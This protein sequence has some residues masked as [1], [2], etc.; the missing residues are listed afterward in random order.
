MRGSAVFGLMLLCSSVYAQAPAAKPA[1]YTNPK[2]AIEDRVADLLGRMT[3]PEKLSILALEAPDSQRLNTPAIP[4]L[5]VPSLRTADAPQG[6]HDGQVTVFPTG[7]TMASTF[8]PALIMKVGETIGQEAR[9]RDRQV[10]YG[11]DLNMHRTPQG[12]RGFE[13]F[14][15]DPFLTATM[16]V[17]YVK[18][19]QSQGVAACAKHFVCND[20]ETGRHDINTVV[21]DHALHEIYLYPFEAA[22]KE[23][24]IWT[25]MDSLGR[26]NG[27]WAASSIPLQIDTLKGA[28]GFDGVII[29]DWGSVHDTVE[30]ANAGTDI[31]MP[32]PQFFSADNLNAALKS[33][34]VTQAVID[35]K[36]RRII[37]LMVRTGRL[38]GTKP[39]DASVVNSVPH[40]K[41]ALQVAREGIVLLRN[42]AKILPLD[43]ARINSIAVIGPNAAV[44]QLGG[45]WSA[46][47]TPA[48]SVS[49]L[50]GIKSKAG[51]KIKINY[52]EGTP[53]TTAAISP[54]PTEFLTPPDAKPGEHGLRAE[55]FTNPG[56][57]GA[58][59]LT[60]V[61]PQI[62]FDWNSNQPAPTV[63]RENFSTRWTGT[64][65]PTVTGHYTMQLDSDDGSRL[66]I[67][68]K[69]I[70]DYWS[71]HG[72]G[73]VQA[74]GI[75][76]VAGKAYKI[77]VEQFQGGGGA[78]C[79]LGW[80]APTPGKE[81]F[82][83]A[84]AAAKASDVAVVVVGLSNN[85]E[86]EELDPPDLYLPGKQDALIQAVAA[87][88]KN[89]IVVLANGTP[90]LMEKWLSHV[91]AV[92]EQWYA[93]QEAGN[94]VAEVLFGDTN[95]SGRL[96]DTLAARR[97]DYPDFGN[98]PGSNGVVKYEEGIYI[99]Y[100]HFDKKN[101][102]PVYPF[103]YGLSYTTFA[104]SALKLPAA[105]KGGQ[106]T[107]A[108]VTVRNTGARAGA[109]VAQLYVHAVSPKTD[110]PVRELKSFQRVSLEPGA[111]ATLTLPLDTRAFS[112]YDPTLKKWVADP[113][114]YE[115]QVGESS[116]D[117]RVKGVVKV[118]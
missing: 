33:G 20:Q 91:P 84:I 38:D 83:E 4:R 10:I 6:V 2:A 66:F 37:R 115:I 95:P 57:Q 108:Q 62:N 16:G 98:Y 89:T 1:V 78:G 24:H 48:Y 92:V 118:K 67:D 22:V 103:G 26:V 30:A 17:A 3:L 80:I 60:R 13:S 75:D 25:I 86:G 69:Q 58:P 55:Y 73:N 63:P 94:A 45:R 87:A 88:N 81:E 50:D 23:A 90:I 40:Q 14:G 74:T 104:Y 107:Q 27:P 70:I 99:G 102:A 47:V 32:Q 105:V 56:L 52:A 109:T 111:K 112:R 71:G 106:P 19:M 12:G 77:R 100:R 49:I 93:G 5:G 18:G 54:I 72:T 29:S 97:Q 85:I 28:W 39:L 36:V 35:E 96:T 53:L 51:G 44:N 7:I 113:G 21:D 64:L 43:R 41:L 46:D 68:D 101:I 59:A 82:T 61:D 34:K 65:T 11:P 110:R 8:D 42:Q 116:R 31:E 9:A 117:I 114:I 76:L 15:E 79:Y